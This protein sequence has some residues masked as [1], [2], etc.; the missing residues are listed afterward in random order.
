MKVKK[1]VESREPSVTD[2]VDDETLCKD[3]DGEDYAEIEEVFK[4]NSVE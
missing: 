3:L 1:R 4:R 2:S